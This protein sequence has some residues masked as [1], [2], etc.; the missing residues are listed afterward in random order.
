MDTV[1][2]DDGLGTQSA[3]KARVDR[4]LEAIELIENDRVEASRPIL[5]ALIRED[6]DNE[7]AWLW[8]SVAVESIDQAVIC[9]D[10]VLKIN[11]KNADAA[12][13]LYQLRKEEIADEHRRA[14]LR[15]YRDWAMLSLGILIITLL[16]AILISSSLEMFAAQA[17]SQ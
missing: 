16:F 11:P 1:E 9:L 12:H 3:K 17:A 5:R 8:M 7:D 2:P 6:S 4:L 10:N 15:I 14:R 13:A